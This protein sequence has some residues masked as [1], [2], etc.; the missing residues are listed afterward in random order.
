MEICF[1][2]RAAR[3]SNKKVVRM[4]L[5]RGATPSVRNLV[6]MTPLHLACLFNNIDITR[7]STQMMAIVDSAIQGGG[8]REGQSFVLKMYHLNYGKLTLLNITDYP[9]KKYVH[10]QTNQ[11]ALLYIF[12]LL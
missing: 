8:A 10:C 6:G 11:I 7:V 12:L 9:V 2:F 4:L 1:L 5:D 3:F